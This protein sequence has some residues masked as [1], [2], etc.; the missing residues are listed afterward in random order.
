M[1]KTFVINFF[2][3]VIESGLR[4]VLLDLFGAGAETTSTTLTWTFLLL[5]LNPDKQEKL[6]KEIRD[7]V[8]FSRNVSLTDRPE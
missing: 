8:G 3:L 4:V 7:V 2:S 6:F 1:P 5:A